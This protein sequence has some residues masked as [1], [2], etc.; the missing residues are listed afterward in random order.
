MLFR[1]DPSVAL[2]SAYGN[3]VSNPLNFSNYDSPEARDLL[4]EAKTVAD[5]ETRKALYEQV[6][7]IGAR[8][9]PMWY[10]GHTATALGFEEGIVGLDDWVLPDGTL[11]IGHP[12]AIPRTYQM[13]RTDG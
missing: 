10:S 8:D 2:G 4:A 12:S 6:G 7:L 9:V 13:W 1:S 3:P 11:G 5:F